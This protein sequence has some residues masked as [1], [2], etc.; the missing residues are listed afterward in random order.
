M[1]H[2][3]QIEDIEVQDSTGI[4]FK[5]TDLETGLKVAVRRFFPFGPN[6]GGLNAEEQVEY[7][8]AL[9]HL[10]KIDHPTLRAIISGG[11]D[12]VD[13]MP[14]IATEWLEG[15]ALSSILRQRPL[16]QPEAVVLLSHALEACE[17]LSTV[18]GREGVWIETDPHVIII[19]GEGTHRPVTFWISPLRWLGQ[20]SGQKGFEPLV[21][22]TESVMGWEPG[23]RGSHGASGLGKWL[24]WLRGA[25]W[26]V[27]LREVR[28][29]LAASHRAENSSVATR[30]VPQSPGS[31]KA[32]SRTAKSK[33]AALVWVLSGC[34]LTV[35]GL[36]G[37]IL[38]QKNKARIAEL[39]GPLEV[40]SISIPA[41]I[42]LQPASLPDAPSS[43]EVVV[44]EQRPP[45]DR[46]F[47]EK[48]PEEATRMSRDM[49][50]KRQQDDAVIQ[51]RREAVRKRGDIY[52]SGDGDLLLEKKGSRIT[53]E[54]NLVDT[55][56]SGSGKTF[57][58]EFSGSDSKNGPRGVVSKEDFTGEMTPGFF[59][60]LTGK[61]IRIKGDAKKFMNRP[62]IT[63]KTPKDVEVAP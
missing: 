34:V 19:G 17:A 28:E 10:E 53:F 23:G 12:A 6:G 39:S 63:I 52:L 27:S 3:F 45:S 2:R 13:G 1:A 14:F 36:T 50:A 26:S 32:G 4:V 38:I 48:S 16:S 25:T 21:A 42:S 7:A 49:M 8:S 37:W 11:C 57:Y 22:L 24:E 46:E 62:E 31:G 5:A 29:R 51:A 20:T 54:G 30:R 55:R 58:L 61:K 59:Q 40:E 18:L 33:S 44:I 56:F 60:Q 41:A 9:G 43:T 15:V 35:F 47:R